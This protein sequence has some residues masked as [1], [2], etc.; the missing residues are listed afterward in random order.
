[1]I[2]FGVEDTM[3]AIETGALE[4]ICLFEDIDITR[5]VIKHPI[6]GDTKTLYLNPKQAKE[7]R[8]FKDQE[9]GIDLEVV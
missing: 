4:T 1:M 9:A 3:K 6:K 5:Y 8:Y 2:V 7:E